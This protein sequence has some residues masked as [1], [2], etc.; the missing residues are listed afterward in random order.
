MVDDSVLFDLSA[1]YANAIDRR[2]APRLL[3]VFTED[4]ELIAPPMRAG[5]KGRSYRGRGGYL[6]IYFQ[7]T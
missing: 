1:G 4:A 5:E 7:T 6:R 2:D 3:K